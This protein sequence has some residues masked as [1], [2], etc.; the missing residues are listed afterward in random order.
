MT[1]L[2]CDDVLDVASKRENNCKILQV[3]V[4]LE[5][6]L[7]IYCSLSALNTA[8]ALSTCSISEVCTVGA[9]YTREF[10]TARTPSTRTISAV[11]AAHIPGTRSISAILRV[12]AVPNTWYLK[13][14]K[15]T[16]SM[17]YSGSTGAT[18]IASAYMFCS[19]F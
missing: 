10:C 18:M 13:Y 14:S 7:L 1:E 11:S 17:K 6:I 4:I 8:H 19:T 3:A 2:S 12:L 9:A 15:Y 16:R 5:S